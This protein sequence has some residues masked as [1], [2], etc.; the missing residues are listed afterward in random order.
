MGIAPLEGCRITWVIQCWP[1][2]QKEK[3]SNLFVVT[4][5]TT[6][7]GMCCWIAA[8]RKGAADSFSV[9]CASTRIWN[10]MQ[11]PWAA[12]CLHQ[13]CVC[14][15]VCVHHT[16]TILLHCLWIQVP[17]FL[18]KTSIFEHTAGIGA[19]GDT[20]WAWVCV[21]TNASTWFQAFLITVS[22]ITFWGIW[23]FRKILNSEMYLNN[24]R[25]KYI[26]DSVSEAI[27]RH[28]SVNNV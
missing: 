19:Q 6:L 11:G 1:A 5:H 27:V 3:R 9:V 8:R 14:V 21:F 15:C 7:A 17:S 20:W 13:H 10:L 16:K 25:S 22:Y 26:W 28:L 2:Q 23:E 4:Q 24:I 18:I 12:G